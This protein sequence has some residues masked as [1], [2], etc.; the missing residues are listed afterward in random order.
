MVHFQVMNSVNADVILFYFVTSECH[1]ERR[2]NNSHKEGRARDYTPLERHAHT[3]THTHTHHTC[4]STVSRERKS[5]NPRDVM[6]SPSMV[7]VPE[8]GSNKRKRA[9]VKDDLPAPVL[10]TMP[11]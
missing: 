7:I 8:D 10:P 2:K 1:L 3:H 5:C 4:G 11:T 6:S 9:K